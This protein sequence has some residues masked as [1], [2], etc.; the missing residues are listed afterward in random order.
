[1]DELMFPYPS[2]M[3]FLHPVINPQH[4]LRVTVVSCVCLCICY[5]YIG[6]AQV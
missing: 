6:H 5:L 3:A 1:M 2:V 4:M